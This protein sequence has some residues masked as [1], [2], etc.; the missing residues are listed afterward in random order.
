MKIVFILY[1]LAGTSGSTVLKINEF[2][3]QLLCENA[4]KTGSYIQAGKVTPL[5]SGTAT[6]V[7]FACIQQQSS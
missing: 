4:A 6:P 5:G 2:S 3:S 7:A 1:M